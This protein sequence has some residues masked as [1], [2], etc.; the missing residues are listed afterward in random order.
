MAADAGTGGYWLVASDGGI[1]AFNARFY[2]ST[3][4]IVLN[5]PIVGM[6]S[7]ATGSGYRF[8]A[9]DG[10]VFP[11]GTS[12]FYATPLFAPPPAPPPS[13]SPSCTVSLSNDNPPQYSSVIA[14]ITSNVPNTAVTMTK[15]YQKTTSSQF[16]T[17]DSSGT[18][19]ISFNISAPLAGVAV[20]V[21]VYVG[22]A[23]CRT[24]FTPN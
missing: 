14:T 11:Y 1:F 8:V 4:S 20:V 5:K 2:G 17:T 6:E 7:D 21:T 22:A 19:T 9:A 23:T 10:G 12:G 24:S 3:G 16:G 18:A 15:T 13:G